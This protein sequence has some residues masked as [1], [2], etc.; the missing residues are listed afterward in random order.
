MSSSSWRDRPVIRCQLHPAQRARQR[1]RGKTTACYTGR[2][3]MPQHSVR[4]GKRTP[5]P[6]ARGLHA[7]RGAPADEATILYGG[8]RAEKRAAHQQIVTGNS[9]N[10][11]DSI[12]VVVGK[13]PA[14][15]TEVSR[16]P[17][18]HAKA[19]QT[20]T[21]TATESVAA[22]KRAYGSIFNPNDCNLGDEANGDGLNAY[23]T[24]SFENQRKAGSR[25][26]AIPPTVGG[27]WP[28]FIPPPPPL[29]IPA[30][31]PPQTLPT[32]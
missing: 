1:R 32:Q 30:P 12:A 21:R 9:S 18:L 6:A 31:P 29:I 4:Q 16:I 19:A 8:W 22:L 14:S 27:G 10:R 13:V 5:P 26:L 17:A 15:R 2:R 24:R 20:V 11:Y 7:F 28:P 23:L 3:I 25:V